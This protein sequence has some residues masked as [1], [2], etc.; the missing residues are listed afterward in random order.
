MA[1]TRYDG[2]PRLRNFP[3]R[4]REGWPWKAD[5]RSSQHVCSRDKRDFI[6]IV[7]DKKG[8]GDNME[9]CFLVDGSLRR[10]SHWLDRPGISRWLHAHI[11]RDARTRQEHGGK[12]ELGERF[13]V[14]SLRRCQIHKNIRLYLD[15]ASLSNFCVPDDVGQAPCLADTGLVQHHTGSSRLSLPGPFHVV[16]TPYRDPDS[17]RQQQQCQQQEPFSSPVAAGC[18]RWETEMQDAK[19]EVGWFPDLG[20][21][22]CVIA[23]TWP[24]GSP[25]RHGAAFLGA[26]RAERAQASGRRPQHLIEWDR[27]EASLSS[28]VPSHAPRPRD[29]TE[30]HLGSGQLRPNQAAGMPL[31]LGWTGPG[32]N[33]D[34]GSI[35]KS[36]HSPSTG[37]Y[38]KVSLISPKSPSEEIVSFSSPLMIRCICRLPHDS[39]LAGTRR[40]AGIG[41]GVGTNFIDLIP[42]P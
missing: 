40:G 20:K 10:W 15:C 17:G 27:P 8:A 21:F 31:Q 38:H 16:K 3:A 11:P 12:G 18:V 5:A 29:T 30:T 26:V 19:E 41:C 25:M 39:Y 42:T 2:D 34:H 32:I 35:R 36:D 4:S 1:C 23:L 13:R 37:M 33:K 6:I 28:P 9:S 22:L 24:C 14:S 7:V